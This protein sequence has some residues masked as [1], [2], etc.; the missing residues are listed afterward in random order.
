MHVLHK[1]NTAF[2]VFITYLAINDDMYL[3]EVENVGRAWREAS[4]IDNW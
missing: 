4:S 1:C 2:I 3:E